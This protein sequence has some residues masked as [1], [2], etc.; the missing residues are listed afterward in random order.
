VTRQNRRLT[1]EFMLALAVCAVI[2]VFDRPLTG[3]VGVG[4]CTL[5]F[6][7]RAAVGQSEAVS[8]ASNG[9]A[10][11]LER[12]AKDEHPIAAEQPLHY[13]PTNTLY[14]PPER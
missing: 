10:E 2:A 12:S 8:S 7:L 6:A 13:D 1:L 3:L 4:L 11:L 5:I 9:S 14:Y